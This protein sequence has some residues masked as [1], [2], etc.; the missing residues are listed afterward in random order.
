MKRIALAS[1]TLFNAACLPGPVGALAIFATPV[2]AQAAPSWNGQWAGGWKGG[3]G[4]QVIF[5]GDDVI[6]LYWR[7]DY[8]EDAHGA[9]ASGGAISISWSSGKAILTRE[10]PASARI[11]IREPGKPD[12]S[13]A[14]KK[15]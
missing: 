7:G 14:L 4:A 9:R 8:I 11:V 12:V 2:F 13:F 10:G 3:A 5:A 6:G 1:L 15:D